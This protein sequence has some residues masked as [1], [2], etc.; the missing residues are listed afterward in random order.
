MP[1]RWKQIATG[2]EVFL[3]ETGQGAYAYS[4]LKHTS[5]LL[6]PKGC[7]L[8]S[9]GDEIALRTLNERLATKD[10]ITLRSYEPITRFEPHRVDLAI[11]TQCNLACA[12][13]HANA[14]SSSKRM[15]KNVA[16]TAVNFAI[17]NAARSKLPYAQVG[18]NGGGEPTANFAL[19][20]DVVDYARLRA[21][22]L[23]TR[24]TFGMATNAAFRQEICNYVGSNFSHLSV[25]LDGPKEIHDRHRPTL[26]GAGS[27]DAVF[28]NAKHLHDSRVKDFNIRATVS[29]LS[30]D[31]LEEIVTFFLKEFPRAGYSFMPINR[32]GRGETCTINPPD[33]AA[34]IDAFDE[35]LL[36][37]RL[38]GVDKV[39]F[40]CGLL[41]TLRSTFCDAF[42]GPGFNVNVD[43]KLASCQRD[44]LPNDFYFGEIS[45]GHLNIDYEKI[46]LFRQPRIITEPKCKDCF[47]KYNCGGE[48]MDLVLHNQPRCEAIQRWTAQQLDALHAPKNKS[49][50]R[51]APWKN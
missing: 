42:S 48:C 49:T 18:F 32:L 29:E 45:E 8:L 12:Y 33:P 34:Y 16:L 4:P 6:T 38:C 30:V 24:V 17:E 22:E 50:Q 1:L 28:T 26:R 47:A 35:I 9:A 43:G 23:G 10:L 41:S 40:M 19:M 3:V 5:F 14:N 27:F 25:S 44:N 7:E 11:T 13:C 36:R 15:D 51:G 37:K 21:A 31:R 46:N 2:D 39:F 20:H